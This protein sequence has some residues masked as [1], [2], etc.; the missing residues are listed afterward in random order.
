MVHYADSLPA[1]PLPLWLSTL[2]DICIV[3]GMQK[4]LSPIFTVY[5]QNLRRRDKEAQNLLPQMI[6]S[7]MNLFVAI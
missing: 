1:F 3:V 2:E 7:T 4:T 6:I 5:A